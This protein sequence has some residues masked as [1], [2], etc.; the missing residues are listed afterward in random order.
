MTLVE[1]KEEVLLVGAGSRGGGET[2]EPNSLNPNKQGGRV[3][4]GWIYSFFFF[5][6]FSPFSLLFHHSVLVFFFFFFFFNV[7]IYCLFPFSLL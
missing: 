5:F 4:R 1:K 6:F 7:F 3:I 2:K